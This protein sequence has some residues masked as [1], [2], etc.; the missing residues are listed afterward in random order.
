MVCPA[1][2]PVPN[3][4]G[5][6][7]LKIRDIYLFFA[8]LL[9]MLVLTVETV[10]CRSHKSSHHLFWRVLFH[11]C[12]ACGR[13]GHRGIDPPCP[14]VKATCPVCTITHRPKDCPVK[15]T[16]AGEQAENVA[17][18][19]LDMPTTDGNPFGDWA[20]HFGAEELNYNPISYMKTGGENWSDQATNGSSSSVNLTEEPEL[21]NLTEEPELVCKYTLNTEP[22]PQYYLK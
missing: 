18:K 2:I 3:D 19:D 9:V 10:I 14:R 11:R 8:F 13:F 15:K 16:K 4:D 5:T 17:M 7:T 12:I 6:I 20:E 1:A 22:V 21:V